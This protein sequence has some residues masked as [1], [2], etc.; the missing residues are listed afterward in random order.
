MTASSNFG[1]GTGRPTWSL[2]GEAS[3]STISLTGGGGIGYLSEIL[4]L[5]WAI[6]VFGTGILHLM[7][8]A[9]HLVHGTP[10]VA[11]SH[12]TCPQRFSRPKKEPR[13]SQELADSDLSCTAGLKKGSCRQRGPRFGEFLDGRNALPGK[14]SMRVA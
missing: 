7:E 5:F 4:D 12:R 6:F 11:A 14:L 9:R 2:L 1:S 8:K 3:V 13:K 10:P